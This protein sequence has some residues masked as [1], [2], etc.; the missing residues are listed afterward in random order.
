MPDRQVSIIIATYQVARYLPEFLGSLVG[1]RV[2]LDELELIFVDDGSTDNSA[3]IIRDWAATRAPHTKVISQA[4][5]GPAAAR[6]TGLDA[7]TGTWLTFADPDDRFSDNYF[8]E[9]NGFLASDHAAKVALVATNLMILEDETGR[10]TDTHPLHAKFAKG[11]RIVDLDQDPRA[12]H[13]QGASAFYRREVVERLQLRFDPEVRPNFE[14]AYFTAIYLASFDH[15]TLALLPEPQYHYRR[16]SDGSSLVQ[17]SWSK[18]EKYTVLPKVGY[19]RLLE[20]VHA[21]RGFVPDWVQ[22]IVLYDLFFYFRTDVR[23]DSPT[24]SLPPEVTDEFHRTLERIATYLDADVIDKYRVSWT[25]REMRQAVLV[26]AKKEYARPIAAGLTKLDPARQLVRLSYYFAGELPAE[27][28]TLGGKVVT[29]VYRK[30]RAVVFLNK[31]MMN[32]R[33]VWLPATENIALRVD[34]ERVTLRTWG[35]YDGLYFARPTHIWNSLARRSVPAERTLGTNQAALRRRARTMASLATKYYRIAVDN[36]DLVGIRLRD[37][38][39]ARIARRPKAREKYRKAWLLMDR[40]SSAQDNAEHLYR[41]LRHDQPEINAWFVLSR[42]STDWDRLSN[43]GFRLIEYGSSEHF[44]ALLNCEQLV[45]SQ[46]DHYVVAPFS[47][48]KL[49][50]PNWRY[51]FLQHGVTKDDLS[52]WINPKPIDLFITVTPDE[53]ELIAGDHTPY[54][55]TSLET[56]MTGF[57]RHDRL[58]ELSQHQPPDA[59]RTLL[60]MP[61][62]RRELLGERV[63]GGNDREL[64]ADFW[65]TDYARAWRGF[66]ESERLRELC[67]RAGWRLAFVPHPNMQDYLASSPLPSYVTVYRFRDIDVQEVLV[68]AAA[69]VTDYSSL[70][71]EAA[72]IKRPVV[73]Y[74]F[75]HD[76]FFSGAHA[77]RRGEWDYERSGFG[78]V[79]HTLE[80]AI[81]A[82]AALVDRGGMPDPEY[83]ARIEK[84]FPLQDGKCSERTF[85]AI[86][87]LSRRMPRRDAVLSRS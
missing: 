70:A 53:Q 4:N 62:W 60:V 75:D 1:Q 79:T 63:A 44:V 43:E 61:T 47:R 35:G 14:D 71:F 28:F 26:G 67:E 2:P 57:P 36:P 42:D 41:Y 24:P 73:Y 46:I 16:R 83:A 23:L 54:T 69:L 86:R 5:A 31:V 66:L 68:S 81:D 21:Q 29:P 50:R 64:I 59:A 11:R 45:S 22:N 77:Y 25:T 84:T 9:V 6:N 48:H 82:V 72:Y 56:V 33:I 3:A 17:A 51:T 20:T 10:V 55:L 39:I 7:A 87:A 32:E 19:L 85:H 38:V 34:G 27:E 37:P 52:R 30:I 15:P 76:T 78:P 8:A 13:L 74:H 12:I 58:L 49:P 40:D 65:N 18:P 80:D